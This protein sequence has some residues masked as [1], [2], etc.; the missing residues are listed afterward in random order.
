MVVVIEKILTLCFGFLPVAVFV[1]WLLLLRWRFR[2]VR[3]TASAGSLASLLDF[4]SIWVWIVSLLIG[5]A[6]LFVGLLGMAR[7][8]EGTAVA[9][10]L[11]IGAVAAGAWYASAVLFWSTLLA[12]TLIGLHQRKIIIDDR[13]LAIRLHAEL[14]RRPRLHR[15]L[16]RCYRSNLGELVQGVL[17]SQARNKAV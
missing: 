4:L 11:A 9:Q 3:Q 14:N 17:G 8:S 16:C 5:M 13:P 6:G 1:A 12:N 10:G 2:A 15:L 7:G